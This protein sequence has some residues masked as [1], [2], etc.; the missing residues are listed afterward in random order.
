VL[1]LPPS[2]RI[3]FKVNAGRS[4]VEIRCAGPSD[5]SGRTALALDG[6]SASAHRGKGGVTVRLERA[7]DVLRTHDRDPALLALNVEGE[8]YPILEDL[9]RE[10]LTTRIR[11]LLIQ[12]H[13]IA[14]DSAAR[15]AAIGAGLSRSH[16]ATWSHP[17]VWERW[18]RL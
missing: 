9:L 1:E 8:E 3:R 4:N 2:R 13:R 11:T 10:G 17:F 16:A 18:D 6:E 15:R 5:R 14:P 7:A 12:F